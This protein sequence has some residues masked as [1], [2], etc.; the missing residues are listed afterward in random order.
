MPLVIVLALSAA[1]PNE[2]EKLFRDMEKKIN[3]AKTLECPVE[4]KMEDGKNSI[5]L[6]YSLAFAEGN[7]SHLE[8]TGTR[9]G[10]AEKTTIISD[11][12]KLRWIVNG[13]AKAK[14]DPPK[15][16][17]D[18]FRGSI[19]RTGV[20][21]TI[22]LLTSGIPEKEFKLDEDFKITDFKLGK[23]EKVGDRDAQVIQ[24]NLTLRTEKEPQAV[25]M[26]LDSKTNLP[27]KRVVTKLIGTDKLTLTETYPN[28]KIDEKIDPKKFELPKD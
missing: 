9:D 25:A 22:I 28:L 7:K 8:M 14:V 16:L 19:T 21:V 24:Y 5:L 26:W 2:A 6:K 10:N 1:E 12:T 23:K 18:I 20:F 17:G 13:T 3:S 11:G 27:L 4:G 15:Q